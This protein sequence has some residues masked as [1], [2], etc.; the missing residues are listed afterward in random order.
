MVAE[1]EYM[2]NQ[3][4]IANIALRKFYTWLGEEDIVPA[5]ELKL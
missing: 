1:K 2:P 3:H 4:R 5:D